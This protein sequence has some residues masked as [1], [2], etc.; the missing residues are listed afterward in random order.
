LKTW[1]KRFV[2]SGSGGLGGRH[3][4]R[5]LTSIVNAQVKATGANL[6]LCQ[7]GFDD[8]A[9]HLLMQNKLPAI[10]WVGGPELEVC[11]VLFVCTSQRALIVG[12]LRRATVVAGGDCDGRAHC[13]A[14]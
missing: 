11:G 3:R 5:A 14:V 10:R 12:A 8:E 2:P 6:V 9:N 7:W 1:C 13:A 4:A